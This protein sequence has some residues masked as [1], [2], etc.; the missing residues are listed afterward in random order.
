[1][2]ALWWPDAVGMVPLALVTHP[3]P[4]GPRLLY[5]F[6]FSVPVSIPEKLGT[7]L[8]SLVSKRG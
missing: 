1:M 4:I 6:Q 2:D 3:V 7:H 5:L 8:F